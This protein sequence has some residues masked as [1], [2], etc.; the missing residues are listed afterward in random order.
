[1]ALRTR[2]WGLGKLLLLLCGLTATFLLF[3]LVGMRVA[4]R[5]REVQVP[6]L[7]GLQADGASQSLAALGLTLRIDPNL[8]ADDRVPA[9]RIVQ[10]DPTS[11][12]QARRQRTIH[13]WVSS[14]P[15]TTTVPAL[16]GQSERTAR[17]RLTEEGLDVSTTSEFRSPDYPADA[18]VAQDPAPSSRA[19]QV[20]LL[21]NRAE[22]AT[23]YV[24]PDLI[25][26]S[27]E[28]AAETL[29]TRGF[30]VTIVGS[31][32]YARVPPG[33]VVR[34]QPSGGFRVAPADPI[35]LEVSR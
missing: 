16:V 26:T 31:Q 2:V 14:G 29:R 20:S 28:R 25:G 22:E 9:G 24:M 17:M 8:R 18:V 12:S 10:Q 21:L 7:V 34:Q 1:M 6:D 27:G 19:P 33:T 4:V 23:T 11:G 13:V 5:A 3:A 35:S 15:R 32:P 30:R